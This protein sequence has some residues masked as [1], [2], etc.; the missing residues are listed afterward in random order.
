VAEALVCARQRPPQ[1]PLHPYSVYLYPGASAGRG[2]SKSVL[3]AVITLSERTAGV[4][5]HASTERKSKSVTLVAKRQ[6]R[7]RSP[8]V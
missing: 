3:K 7:L 8:R 5:L 4:N 1:F 6:D 2:A